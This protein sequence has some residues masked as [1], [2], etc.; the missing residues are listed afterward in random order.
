M[1]GQTHLSETARQNMDP[2]PVDLFFFFLLVDKVP[3]VQL[4]LRKT[5][6]QKK[7]VFKNRSEVANFHPPVS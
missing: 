2:H 1:L 5:Q 7:H 6:E 4:L 3:T